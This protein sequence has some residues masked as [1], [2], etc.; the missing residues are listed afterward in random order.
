MEHP[1]PTAVFID[2]DNLFFGLLHDR[3][4]RNH[5]K[6]ME[7]CMNLLVA[8]RSHLNERD[9]SILLGRAYS[10]FDDYPGK[11][12]AH[13]LALLGF[14]PRYVLT[15]KGKNTAD[16]QLSLDLMEVLLKRKDI[17]RFIVVGGARYYIP[18]ACKA[19]EAGAELL[20]ASLPEVT[21]GDLLDRVGSQRFIDLSKLMTLPAIHSRD[22]DYAPVPEPAPELLEHVEAAEDLADDHEANH[23]AR[24]LGHIELKGSWT[25]ISDEVAQSTEYQERCF[26]LLENLFDYFGDKY[27]KAEVWLGPFLKKEMVD[28]FPDLTH[29]QRRRIINLLKDQGRIAIEEREGQPNPFSVVIPGA[30]VE[31]E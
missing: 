30:Q 13:P 1:V 11:D 15:A 14:D 27:G 10:T 25:P 17:E 29:P 31:A 6:A 24:V 2:F 16:L 19:L 8:L 22:E 23:A 20:I 4:H 26:S 5:E 21:S 7:A 12:A 28:R 18:I 3:F 9:S